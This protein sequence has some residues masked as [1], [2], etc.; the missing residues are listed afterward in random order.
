MVFWDAKGVLV[1]FLRRGET[2]DALRYCNAVNRLRDV[3]RKGP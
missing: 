2:V 3:Q 1:D